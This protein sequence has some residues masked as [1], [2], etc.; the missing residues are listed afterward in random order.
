M[1]TFKLHLDNKPTKEGKYNVYIV[2]NIDGKRKHIKTSYQ[3]SRKTDWNQDTTNERWF[4][5][6]EPNHKKWN[7]GLADELESVKVEYRKLKEAGS[8]SSER[9]KCE[10]ESVEKSSSFLGYAKQKTREIYNAGGLR[11]WKKYNGF[12]NKFEGF[13][14]M[15]KVTDVTFADLTPIFLSK[16][17]SYLHTLHNERHPEEML[18]PNSIQ[19]VLNIFKTLVNDSIKDKIFDSNKNPF[20]GF[21]PLSK[22]VSTNKEKLDEADIMALEA[23]NLEE[24]SLLWNCRNAFLFSFYC[25]GVRCGDLLQLK[26]S[27]ITDNGKRIKYTMDKNGKQRDLMLVDE[28]LEILGLYYTEGVNPNN[29]IFPFLDSEAPYSRI[30]E[31]PIE[32]K[33]ALFNR[34]STQNALINKYLNK[35]AKLA[36]I[37]KHI[38]FHIS[39]HSFANVA[40]KA[41]TDSRKIQQLLAH[42][43]LKT[44][45]KYMGNFDSEE[46]DESL[47]GIF[48]PQH[49]EEDTLLNQ[50]RSLSPEEL[51][52]LLK[53]VGA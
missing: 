13:M 51:S 44:T 33:K 20:I 28:A 5:P 19:V 7:A 2:V 46:V 8:V 36:D 4:R 22:S 52:E 49:K 26:W 11:N 6:S 48:K 24:G 25:A 39:R 12:L 50:L 18:H 23:L 16:F 9:V 53:K 45:E 32:V 29:Y 40:K 1:A 43:N 47:K 3:V 14:R 31:M 35:L 27:N 37:E 34:I 17:D 10:V 21:K 30:K 42:S 38:S 41:G 15:Q